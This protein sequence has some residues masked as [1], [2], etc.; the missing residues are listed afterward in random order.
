MGKR[1]AGKRSVRPLW[2]IEPFLSQNL[3]P[4]LHRSFSVISK[5]YSNT[6]LQHFVSSHPQFI[7]QH[8]STVLQH[9]PFRA[10]FSLRCFAAS[11]QY[12]RNQNHPHNPVYFQR[13]LVK[14]HW[15]ANQCDVCPRTSKPMY[16][17]L[18]TSHSCIDPFVSTSF[19]IYYFIPISHFYFNCF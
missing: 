14:P 15:V 2:V 17:C 18:P 4:P 7:S 9:Q 6:K 10:R 11:R 5:K 3:T 19:P 16:V 12:R 8:Y 13:T 1:E